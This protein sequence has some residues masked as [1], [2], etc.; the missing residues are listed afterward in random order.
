MKILKLEKDIR[1]RGRELK[2]AKD[3]FNEDI[4]LKRNQELLSKLKDVFSVYDHQELQRVSRFVGNP[5]D[6]DFVRRAIFPQP[7]PSF[8]F[9]K[10]VE[11]NIFI[12]LCIMHN[13][14]SS[15]FCVFLQILLRNNF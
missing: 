5:V 11:S 6:S 14:M 10:T 12:Q 1:K 13:N 3:A 2:N 8:S 15:I 4:A 9:E 7:H